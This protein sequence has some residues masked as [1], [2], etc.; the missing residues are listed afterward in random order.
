MRNVSKKITFPSD[1]PEQKFWDA[2]M[3]PVVDMNEEKLEWGFPDLERLR[4]FLSAKLGWGKDKI[5]GII[6]PVIKNMNSL[7]STT[8][9]TTLDNFFSSPP[10]QHKSKRVR[11]AFSKKK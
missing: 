9:Q 11:A 2:Y 1:F 8:V 3:K 6:I 4:D 5:D 10:K 7:K